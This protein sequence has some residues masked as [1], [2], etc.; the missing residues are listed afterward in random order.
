MKVTAMSNDNPLD[1]E[2]LIKSGPLKEWLG[3][4][5]DMTLWRKQRTKVLPFPAH[6]TLGGPTKFWRVREVEA[7]IK[8]KAEADAAKRA[9]G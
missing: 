3:G 2:K 1:Q 7:W 6:I 8:A 5:S 4:W 9:E